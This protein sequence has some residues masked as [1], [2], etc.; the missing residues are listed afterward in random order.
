[1]EAARYAR[2]LGPIRPRPREL[3]EPANT[4]LVR[5]LL[6]RVRSVVGLSYSAS[7]QEAV[8]IGLDRRR[9][10]ADE[11]ATRAAEQSVR[12]LSV[13]QEREQRDRERR[14]GRRQRAFNTFLRSKGAVG[15][16]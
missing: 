12:L 16:L 4:D 2:L 7:M 10:T 8:V 11:I 9:L 14:E 3:S 13:A 1:M 6:Q 5:G 15:G